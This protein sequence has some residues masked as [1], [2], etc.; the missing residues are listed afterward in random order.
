LPGAV[1][2]DGSLL[3]VRGDTAGD[4]SEL[5]AALVARAS[6]AVVVRANDPGPLETALA[7]HG[8]AAQGYLH[9]TSSKDA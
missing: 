5:T 7:R 9:T 6:Q 3:V 8:L 2:G 1:R 4:L